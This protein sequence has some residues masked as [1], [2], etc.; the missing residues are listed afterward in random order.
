MDWLVKQ[1]L[2]QMQ[3]MLSVF[4][5]RIVDVN[6]ESLHF[7]FSVTDLCSARVYAIS[8]ETSMRDS[9]F[10]TKQKTKPIISGGTIKNSGFIRDRSSVH[11]DTIDNKIPEWKR[12]YP[13]QSSRKTNSSSPESL[14]LFPN[15]G[16]TASLSVSSGD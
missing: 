6:G 5:C 15:A 12:L 2:M 16:S 8:H 7:M 13:R 4:E 1:T 3:R 11:Q 9:N 10:M 14:G